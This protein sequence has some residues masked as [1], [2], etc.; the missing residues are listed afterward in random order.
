MELKKLPLYRLTSYFLLT[1]C[2]QNFP[3]F[4]SLGALQKRSKQSIFLLFEQ[5]REQVQALLH[6]LGFPIRSGMTGTFLPILLVNLIWKG[7]EKK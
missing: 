4:V 3:P 1:S 7:G 6:L 5:S 2:G